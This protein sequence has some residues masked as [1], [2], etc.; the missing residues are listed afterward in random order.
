MLGCVAFTERG[1]R[2]MRSLDLGR[3]I[4]NCVAAALL[5]GCGGAQPPIGVLGTM[6]RSRSDRLR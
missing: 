5:A 4:C 1:A 2:G 3:Y 6:P